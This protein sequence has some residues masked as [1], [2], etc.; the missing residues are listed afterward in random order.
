MKFSVIMILCHLAK[1][2]G[3]TDSVVPVTATRF[4]ISHLGLKIKTRWYPWYS[5]GQVLKLQ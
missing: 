5:A 4:A 3:D 2:S 1:C